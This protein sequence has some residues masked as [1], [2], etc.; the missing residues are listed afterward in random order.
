MP[1]DRPGIIMRR[2]ILEVLRA[3]GEDEITNTVAPVREAMTLTV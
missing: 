3:H 1:S 2:R